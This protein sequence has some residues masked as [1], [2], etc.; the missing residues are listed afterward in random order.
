MPVGLGTQVRFGFTGLAAF[1]GLAAASRAFLTAL[2]WL[3]MARL[4]GLQSRCR[5]VFPCR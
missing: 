5:L 1:G 4:Q 3:N 2:Y